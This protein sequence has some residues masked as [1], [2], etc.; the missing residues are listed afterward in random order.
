MA[1]TT[2]TEQIVREAP[3]IEA[4]RLGLIESAKALSDIKRTLPTQQVAGLPTDITDAISTARTGLGAFQ[5]YVTAAGAGLGDAATTA[6]LGVSQAQAAQTAA[7]GAPGA[8]QA[9]MVAPTTAGLQQFMD[10]YQKAVIDESLAEI[11]RQGQLQE[12]QVA[13]G[14]LQAGAFGGAR[15]GVQEAELQ[16]GLQE[17]RNQIVASL[18]QQ[19]YQQAMGAFDAQRRREI[20]GGQALGQL[21]PTFGALAGQ[22]GQLGQLQAGMGMQQAQLGGAQQQ[23]ATADVDLQ[24]RLGQLQ[25]QQEQKQLEATRLNQ[26][27][28]ISEPYERVGWLSDIYKG[29]PTTQ[30][31]MTRQ[32]APSVSPLMQAGAVGLAGLTGAAAAKKLGLF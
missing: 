22:F 4:Y 6:G 18:N 12:Q 14:A 13:A 3:D 25:Q 19:N 2:I 28:D 26:L 23:L 16:R 10:P 7:A 29:I 32:V 5:P 20:A 9:G 15:H 17:R 21:A 27:Q 31:S 11:D 30:Q 8:I 1:E 24:T